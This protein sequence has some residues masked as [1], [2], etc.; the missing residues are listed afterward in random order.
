MSRKNGLIND[1]P[2]LPDRERLRKTILEKIDK[3]SLTGCWIW[4]GAKYVRG[5]GFLLL[6]NKKL[7]VHRAAY[8]LFNQPIIP[9]M[10]ILHSCDNPA[11][12]NPGHLRQGTHKENVNDAVKRGRIATG[13]RHGSKTVPGCMKRGSNHGMARL[14]E[15]Q[16]KT[17][18][19]LASNG[20]TQIAIAQC[21]GVA[22]GTVAAI[23]NMRTWRFI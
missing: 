23:V 7:L 14:N 4:Q 6:K 16:V 3:Y 9:G 21:F 22:R 15:E 5:Y 20:E 10:D 19:D 12:C 8:I 2:Y 11:C 1:I 13:D 17:I 18:R